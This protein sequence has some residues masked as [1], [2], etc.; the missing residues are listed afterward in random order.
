[1]DNY[2]KLIEALKNG[3][4]PPPPTALIP[5]EVVGITGETCTVMY[6]D[7]ELT[8]VRLK[9]T[10]N[11]NS[12]KLML[13]PKVGSMVLVGSLTGDLNDL[14]VLKIDELAKVEYIQDGFS[15]VLDTTDGKF[16]IENDEVSL[17]GLYQQL[18]TLLKTFK[19]HTPSGP[20]LSLL[21]DTLAKVNQ[22][23]TDFKKLLK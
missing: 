23:E 12:N 1:M 5:V 4:N 19:V 6:G 2:K 22:F 18:T 20:S 13:L 15:L 8:D 17:Y 11:G 10:E 7:L 3:I 21:P 16:S 14:A 9:A